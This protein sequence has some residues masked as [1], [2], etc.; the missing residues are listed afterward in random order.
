MFMENNDDFGDKAA[1]LYLT[2]IYKRRDEQRVKTFF[3]TL[4]VAFISE[5]AI[6]ITYAKFINMSFNVSLLILGNDDIALKA[7]V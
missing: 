6:D 7:A 4:V 3:Y 2:N 1:N 5:T